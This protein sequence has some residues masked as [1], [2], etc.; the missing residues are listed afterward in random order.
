[1]TKVGT[2][3]TILIVEDDGDISFALKVFL[4][5]EGYRV[6]IS[7]NG[8]EA[9]RWLEHSALPSLI[10]LDMKMP[11]MNG[12]EFAREF[13]AR[14]DHKVP[15]LVMTAAV[16]AEKRAAEIAANG[17]VGKPFNLVDLSQKVQ[18]SAA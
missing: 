17:W 7:K 4:E 13:A 1:V 2:G 8:L 18:Q 11:V 5:S 14:Y 12:W 16:D 6:Q 9:L 3:K 10:L 15:I